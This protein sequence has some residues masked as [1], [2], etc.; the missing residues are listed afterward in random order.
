[1]FVFSHLEPFLIA[2]AS[3]KSIA[4][5]TDEAA[6]VWDFIGLG[7]W[8]AEDDLGIFVEVD[9]LSLGT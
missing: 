7:V 2:W 5:F 8:D 1:V 4:I 9:V 3:L 6:E